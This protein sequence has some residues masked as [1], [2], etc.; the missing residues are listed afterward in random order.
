MKKILKNRALELRLAGYSFREISLALNI[1]KS[2]ASLWTKEE[3][4][5]TIARKR[6]EKLEINGRKKAGNINK[7]K[8]ELV[9][10][11]VATDCPNFKYNNYGIN[12]YKIFIALLYW[13]EGAKTGGRFSFINSDPEMV[14]LYLSLLRKTYQIDNS[15]FS[16]WLFIHE[17]HDKY[18]IIEFWSK[19]TT[20]SKKQFHLYIKP[21]TGKNKKENYRVCLSI[22]YKDSRILKEIFII[23]KKLKIFY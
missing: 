13:C 16:V 5:K 6:L 12:E 3:K 2:T 22:R 9:W 15:K 10:Q 1:S 7:K 20:I 17:Y 19:L 23:I 4:L 21:H 8:R 14:K 18:A 11:K